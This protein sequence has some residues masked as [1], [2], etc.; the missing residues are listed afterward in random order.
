MLP[1]KILHD[2]IF[3]VG[4]GEV[5]IWAN[6]QMVPDVYYILI[7]KRRPNCQAQWNSEY[8]EAVLA[9]D[10]HAPLTVY[11]CIVICGYSAG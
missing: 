5:I 8:C 4:T 7:V 3:N 1:L 11:T 2:A 9:F 6:T 10:A